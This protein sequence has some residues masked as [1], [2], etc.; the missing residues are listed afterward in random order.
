MG[1]KQLLHIFISIIIIAA[2][3]YYVFKSVS[4]AEIATALKSVRYIYLLPA[5]FLVAAGYIV[6]VIRWRY[7]IAPVKEVKTINLFSPLIVG[8]MGNML[9]ARAGEVLRA[10][11]LGKREGLSFSASFATIFMERLFD[12][13]LV[14]L[15]LFQMIVPQLIK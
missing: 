11:L 15:L 13:S 8:F 7:L 5:I 6:R 2:S 3:L 4:L 1:K 10:Y 9:P 14:L 12:M